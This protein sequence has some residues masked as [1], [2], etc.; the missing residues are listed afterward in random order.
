MTDDASVKK[1]LFTFKVGTPESE[2]VR[3]FVAISAGDTYD[4]PS[5][6]L[7]VSN[8]HMYLEGS[9]TPGFSNR[10]QMV[11]ASR[12]A[13]ID[14][15][16]N[17][18]L[19]SALNSTGATT[20]I[21]VTNTTGVVKDNWL[22][23][24][25]SS[26]KNLRG[27]SGS[28]LSNKENNGLKIIN[29]HTIVSDSSFNEVRGAYMSGV[30]INSQMDGN[31]LTLI[32]PTVNAKFGASSIIAQ[33]FSTGKSSY[34]VAN[35][36]LWLIGKMRVNSESNQ[37]TE[38]GAAYSRASGVRNNKVF[39]KDFSAE[40]GDKITHY[41]TYGGWAAGDG[42]ANDNSVTFDNSRFA[43][44]KFIYGGIAAKGLANG[45]GIEI[46]NGSQVEGELVGAF[47]GGEKVTNT[48]VTIDDSE[49]IGTISLFS[50]S[51]KN[52]KFGSGTLT[53]L[54]SSDLS[55]AVLQPYNLKRFN[56]TDT[57]LKGYTGQTDVSFVADGFSGVIKQLGS[58]DEMAAFDHVSLLNQKWD[59]EGA[60]LTI[61]DSVAFKRT[62]LSNNSLSF[63]DSEAVAKGGTI[64]LLE[65]DNGISYVDPEESE[66]KEL[67]STA[68]TAL[69]FVGTVKFENQKI[70][71][72]I[73]SIESAEQTIL[74]GDSRLAATAFINQGSDLLERVFHGFTL[75][76]DKYG[77]MTFATAEGTKGDYDLSNP[78]K[79][80]GWNFIAGSRSVSAVAY[81]DLISAA[82][83][84]YGEGNYR[85]TNTH[86]G[87][88]FRT[89]GN[90]RYMGAGLAVRLMT[91][92]DLYLEG[93]MRAGQMKSDLDR[94]LM[95]AAGHYYDADTDSIYAGLHLGVG[96]IANPMA[97]MELDSYAKY[98]FTYT[99]SDSFKIDSHNEKYEFDSITSHRLRLGTRASFNRDNVT[100]MFGLAGEYE[101]DAQSDMIAAGAPARTS[102]LDGFSAF[103]EVG[104]SLKPSV[105]SPWQ[106]DLQVRGWEGTRDAVSGMAT[107]N[108]LF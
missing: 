8:N 86:L 16:S 76:R 89:D 45:N 20:S 4:G 17:Q 13:D 87:Y 99:D 33:E 3:L 82:F 5:S 28:N 79:V 107:V 32:N 60:I 51:K 57:G 19:I 53:V 101:F 77:L 40:F 46:K 11:N 12:V 68:G 54:G 36:Q 67:I 2:P 31:T 92:S 44:G 66:H 52:T 80:N 70:T 59:R 39:F 96:F 34:D 50:G 98:F 30:K 73:D 56:N 27:V 18:V 106:F 26:L 58:V 9:S 1:S 71:Y 93:S 29:N 61:S 6:G 65:S 38:I 108:Y 23:V 42:D 74:V 97:G 25:D 24:I 10:V 64:T 84:E 41:E 47:A 62:S 102:E 75:S 48:Y 91:A 21:S 55:Q 43:G 83:V 104:M 63:I 88:D 7:E 22:S 49:V 81:G 95:D 105:A 72:S 14:I 94:A 15:N 78:I 37:G 100:F 69:E 90:M 85:A 103:A 35:G